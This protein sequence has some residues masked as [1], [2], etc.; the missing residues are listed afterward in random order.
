MRGT[1]RLDAGTVATLVE[2]VLDE[3]V[4]HMLCHHPFRVGLAAKQHTCLSTTI[5]L[6]A[7]LITCTGR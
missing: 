7:M 6:V 3:A 1:T 2:V 5:V 4:D